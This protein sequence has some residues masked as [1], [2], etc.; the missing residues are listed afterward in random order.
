ME[1]LSVHKCPLLRGQGHQQWRSKQQADRARAPLP[2]IL[3]KYRFLQRKTEFLA[4]IL[5]FSRLRRPGAYQHLQDIYT[6]IQ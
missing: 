3:E 4:K 6:Q 2:E 5:N 1:L